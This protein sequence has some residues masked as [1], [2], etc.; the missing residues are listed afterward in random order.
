[1][2]EVLGEIALLSSPPIICVEDLQGNCTMKRNVIYKYFYVS[3]FPHLYEAN[4]H[5]SAKAFV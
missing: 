1:M 5:W 2:D 4:N 3:K